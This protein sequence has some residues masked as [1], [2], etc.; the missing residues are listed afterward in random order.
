MKIIGTGSATPQ[1]AVTNDMLA[2]FLDTSDK[3]ISERTGI[4]ERR[5]LSGSETLEELATIASNKALENAGINAK[6][7]DY[8]ICSN[9][10]KECVTPSLSS[11][12]CGRI[13]SEC[14]CVD[15][16]A[17][18]TGFIFALDMAESFIK[19][20]KAEKILILCA[21][22]PSRLV[23]WAD[24]S[25]CILF[26]D[27][28]GAVVVTKGGT[29]NF[30]KLSTVSRH[31]VLYYHGK[32]EPTPF[33]GEEKYT[34]LK[35]NGQEIFKT[36]VS[37]SIRD[38][39]Y[40]LTENNMNISKNDIKYFI[41]HQANVRIVD[42]IRHYLGVEADKMP[43]NIAEYGNTSSASIPILLDELNRAGKIAAGDWLLLSAFGAGF[44]SGAYL[45]K[46]DKVN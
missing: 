11:V 42:T 27:G 29:D 8:I 22:E 37:A 19:A 16:N 46:W 1:K 43:V 25:T 33:Q 18:C 5:I 7:I 6:E 28:A 45:I 13:G 38:I 14:P 41:L 32:L 3:W 4:K 17:A 2:S 40:V 34:A 21:E 20:N 44:T 31:D 10:A 35:M 36:A 24:R 23:D 15:I 39:K 26:G 30:A 12:I 9:T